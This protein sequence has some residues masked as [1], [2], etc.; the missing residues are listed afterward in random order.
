MPKAVSEEEAAKRMGQPKRR[1]AM[2]YVRESRIVE[3]LKA[4]KARR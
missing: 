4:T 1:K 3:P 2:A